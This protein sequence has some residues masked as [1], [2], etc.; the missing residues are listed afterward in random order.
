[1]PSDAGQL[2]ALYQEG[3]IDASAL[4]AALKSLAPKPQRKRRPE[5][6]SR[7]SPSRLT[8]KAPTRKAPT[9]EALLDRRLSPGVLPGRPPRVSPAQLRPG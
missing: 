5:A 7:K 9:I 3:V 6:L 4:N 2:L 1:M 8:R